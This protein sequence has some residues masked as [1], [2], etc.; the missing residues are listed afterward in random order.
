MTVRAISTAGRRL[1]YPAVQFISTRT[2][3]APLRCALPSSRDQ[4]VNQSI[5]FTAARD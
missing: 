3:P 5:K 4:M 1:I 2:Q